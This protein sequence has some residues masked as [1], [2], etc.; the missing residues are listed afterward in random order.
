[1]PVPLSKLPPG[2]RAKV[3]AVLGG[4]GATRRAMEMGLAPGSEVEVVMVTGG[5]II[6]RVRGSLVA[7][8]RGLAEKVLVEPL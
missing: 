4:R 2:T 8:G 5:P 3:V 7:V 6:V 1:M